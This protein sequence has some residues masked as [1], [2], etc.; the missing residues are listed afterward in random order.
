MSALW[1]ARLHRPE[2][3]SLSRLR[4][5]AG[6]ELC[7]CDAYLWLRGDN[8]E[9]IDLRLRA[10]PSAARFHL[11]PGGELI[12]VGGCVPSD[13]LPEGGW[14][15]LADW[16]RCA[17]P[18]SIWPGELPRPTAVRL[19]RSDEVVEPALLLTTLRDWLNYVT[20][21]PQVR[22]NCWSFAADALGRVIVRGTPLPPLAGTRYIVLDEVA[23]PAG[24]LWSPAISG[25]RLRRV[26]GL[27][28][29]HATAKGAALADL[30]LFL[31]E[32]GAWEL[33]PGDSFVKATR[34][35]VRLTAE[36]LHAPR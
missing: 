33:V 19:V 29:T 7:D 20:V 4:L 5:V 6:I 2:A 35:A 17:W 18:P 10:L 9:A 32:E 31:T 8:F 36:A 13:R 34:S 14:Q 23:V 26:L 21:A 28:D 11:L 15:S 22:L 16:L 24:W 27:D 12:P 3:R 1:A 25:S 30:A